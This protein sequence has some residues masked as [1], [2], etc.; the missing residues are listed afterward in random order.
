MH[1]KDNRMEC[2]HDYMQQNVVPDC[3]LMKEVALQ[4]GELSALRVTRVKSLPLFPLPLKVKS[5]PPPQ[6]SI[7]DAFRT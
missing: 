4:G 3:V 2:F 7:T 1:R 6:R 5:P